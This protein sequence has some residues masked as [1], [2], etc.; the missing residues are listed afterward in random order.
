MIE[1]PPNAWLHANARPRKTSK[2]SSTRVVRRYSSAL[3]S[4]GRIGQS[5]L[6][7]RTWHFVGVEPYLAPSAPVPA[8]HRPRILSR[9]PSVFARRHLDSWEAE[10]SRLALVDRIVDPW[11]VCGTLTACGVCALAGGTPIIK[12]AGR[13]SLEAPRRTIE[14]RIFVVVCCN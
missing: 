3:N 11:V 5:K 12:F 7:V 8:S 6:Q 13:S 4:F 9:S 1:Q 10:G 14:G 2:S